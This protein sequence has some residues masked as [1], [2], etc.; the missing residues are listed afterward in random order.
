MVSGPGT[1]RALTVNTTA[2]TATSE[3]ISLTAP[4]TYTVY[5]TVKTSL[6]NKTGAD[7]TGRFTVEKEVVVVP[8]KVVVCNPANGQ[9]I[10]VEE[11]DAAAYKPV[12]D[13]ACQPKVESAKVETIASTGPAEVLGGVAGLG[14]LTAAGY[15]LR[16][17]RQRVINAFKK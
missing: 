16:A 1:S 12:G 9:T 15:Y 6:G 7:C 14:S 2:K 13:V 3:T 10:T 11:K 8:T 4:G 5:A 17:S